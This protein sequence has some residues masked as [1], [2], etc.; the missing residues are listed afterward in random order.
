MKTLSVKQP[1]A[2]LI[3]A[4]V[5]RVENRT[6]ST[7]YRGR[8]LIHASGNAY[9]FYD[10]EHM[11]PRWTDQF[12]DYIERFDNFDPPPSAPET[13][14]A[15]FRLNRRLF[16][17]YQQPLENDSDIKKW[18]KPAVVKNGYFF[19]SQAIIGEATL[20]NIIQNSD[21][22]FAI[23]GQFHWIMTDPVLYNKPIINVIGHLRLWNFDN[24]A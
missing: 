2:T 21:D 11:P 5:K 18:I 14:Q 10:F 1:N 23:P 17:H 3:C 4:G 6:W 7:D 15:A 9:S 12:L 24:K 22:D 19:I 13:I 20:S 16:E 8:L